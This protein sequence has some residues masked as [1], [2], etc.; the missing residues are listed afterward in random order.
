MHIFSGELRRRKIF[1]PNG[2][3]VR[4]SSGALREAVFNMLSDSVVDTEVL[5]LFAGTGA[6][7]FEA[8]SRGAR[9]VTFIDHSKQS[10]AC[11][12]KNAESLGVTAQCSIIKSDVLKLLARYAKYSKSFDLILADPPYQGKKEDSDYTYSQELL[13]IAEESALLSPSGDLF[14]EEDANVPLLIK[15]LKQLELSS[16]R[17]FGRSSLNHFR[18]NESPE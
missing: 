13:Q 14:I 17:K 15:S 7:G 9:H 5:D 18:R 10:I 3:E 11:I 16:S 4:P 8:L 2:L 12:Q 6:L 1:S